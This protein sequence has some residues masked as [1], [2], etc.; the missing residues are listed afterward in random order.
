M[1]C[2]ELEFISETAVNLEGQIASLSVMTFP[3]SSDISLM[4]NSHEWQFTE[5][6][7]HRNLFLKDLEQ[8]KDAHTYY[9]YSTKYWNSY[10]EQLGKNK[11]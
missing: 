4:T 1:C 3:N 10:P 5:M 2:R 9:F 7:K 8:N 6:V 11:K